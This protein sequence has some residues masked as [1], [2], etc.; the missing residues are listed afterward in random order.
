MASGGRSP[1]AEAV[2]IDAVLCGV[3]ADEAHGAAAVVDL[4]WI[5]IRLDTVIEDKGGHPLRVEPGGDLEALV[6]HGYMLVTSAGND[7]DGGAGGARLRQEGIHAGLIGL[8]VAECAGGSVGPQED[9]GR[10]GCSG[11][12]AKQRREGNG[13]NKQRRELRQTASHRSQY[14]RGRLKYGRGPCCGGRARERLRQ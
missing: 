3:G 6:A 1:D 2:G 12:G 13:E 9:G 5:A 11:L 7:Q 8:G 10:D 14:S 4:D